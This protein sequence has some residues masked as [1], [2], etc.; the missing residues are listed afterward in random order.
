MHPEAQRLI[1][2]FR[3]Q[4]HPEGG[5]YRETYRSAERVTTARG[6][7]RAAT[8]SIYFVL[9]A[10]MFSA[11]HRLASD[12]T[13]HFYRGDPLTLELIDAAGRHERRVIGTD[14]SLQTTI[15]SGTHFAAHIDTEDGYALV[16]CD[17]APGF[18]FADFQLTTR[19]MLTAA[20][21]QFGPLIARYTR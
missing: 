3:L 15:A 17:V 20:Y 18:E 11:F 21:P 1:T 10:Q 4:P 13:W 14:D 6:A 2:A 5:W 19:S 16:G 7:I 12:E 8:T 9:T